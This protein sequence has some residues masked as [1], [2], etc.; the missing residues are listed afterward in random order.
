MNTGIEIGGN[1]SKGNYQLDRLSENEFE[2]HY[3]GDG[4]I[5]VFRTKEQVEKANDFFELFTID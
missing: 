5:S 3:T 2:L 4:W 1:T